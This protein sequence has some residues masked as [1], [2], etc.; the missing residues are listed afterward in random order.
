MRLVVQTHLAVDFEAA[1]F[2]SE[3][4][5]RWRRQNAVSRRTV[6]GS[7][8]RGLGDFGVVFDSSGVEEECVSAVTAVKEEKLHVVS[9]HP[10]QRN[11]LRWSLPA[12]VLYKL[13]HT[14]TS[15]STCNT[16]V[17]KFKIKRVFIVCVI[18]AIKVF[19]SSTNN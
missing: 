11:F 8:V 17:E 3:E 4:Q 13:T 1:G 14:F 16:N 2:D 9:S 15:F 19:C 6:F 12:G 18:Q 10:A 5:K 7:W